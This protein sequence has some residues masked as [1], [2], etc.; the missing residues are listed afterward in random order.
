MENIYLKLKDEVY[1]SRFHIQTL[2]KSVR[3]SFSGDD[4]FC[5][6]PNDLQTAYVVV[7][8]AFSFEQKQYATLLSNGVIMLKHNGRITRKTRRV[9]NT[10]LP[11]TIRVIMRNK[12]FLIVDE[13]GIKHP[14]VDTVTIANGKVYTEGSQ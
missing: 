3:L 2:S 6:S 5:E 8:R 4:P 1:P 14:F 13:E 11:K 12:K 10:I 7:G 9:L